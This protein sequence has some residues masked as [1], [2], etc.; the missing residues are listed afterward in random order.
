MP[1]PPQR[2]QDYGTGLV[3]ILMDSCPTLACSTL[4]GT[5]NPASKAPEPRPADSAQQP[6]QRSARA[7]TPRITKPW[8]RSARA[9]ADA[10]GSA[11]SQL[12]GSPAKKQRLAAA[13]DSAVGA[14]GG[15]SGTVDSPHR[16]ASLTA[17]A[18]VSGVWD[19]GREGGRGGRR[20]SDRGGVASDGG[21][22]FATGAVAAAAGCTGDEAGSAGASPI[23]REASGD[24]G[25]YAAADEDDGGLYEGLQAEGGEDYAGPDS[26]S[27]GADGHSEGSPRRHG[28]GSDHGCDEHSGSQHESDGGYNDGHEDGEGDGV[29]RGSLHDGSHGGDELDFEG[30]EYTGMHGDDV[31]GSVGQHEQQGDSEEGLVQAS[32]EGDAEDGPRTGQDSAGQQQYS[33]EEGGDGEQQQRERWRQ[34]EQPRRVR[35][36]DEEREDGEYHTDEGNYIEYE[37]EPK[38]E[39]EQVRDT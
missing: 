38:K 5:L 29:H 26:R 8:Q 32:W 25:R 17:G 22:D 15:A 35:E 36:E 4:Q 18:G 24:A 39:E 19:D 11:G 16:R 30:T 9:A 3:D 12:D 31:E 1:H 33:D 20:Q 37:E 34:D 21:D 27:I 6:A 28:E 14:S 7:T 10:S 2:L 13:D 23:K